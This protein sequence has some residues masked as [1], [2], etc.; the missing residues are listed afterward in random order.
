VSVRVNKE[1]TFRK[2]IN[3]LRAYAVLAVMFYHF[4]VP[5]FSGGFVGVDV[6]FVISGYLMTKIIIEKLDKPEGGPWQTLLDFYFARAYRIVPALVGLCAVL[7]ALG[8]FIFSS[9]DYKQLGIHALSALLFLSN[10]KFWREAGYFDVASHDKW[11]LHTWSLSVEWQFYLLFPLLVILAWRFFQKRSAIT[12][13]L[14]LGFVV[15]LAASLSL[16]KD[17][18]GAAFYLLP[19]RAWELFAGGL[20]YI[21]ATRV[22]LS[23]RAVRLMEFTGFSVIFFSVSIFSPETLWPGAYALFPVLG[24]VL[25]L[26]AA[27]QTSFITYTQP[28][29]ALGSWSYSVYLWHWPVVVALVWTEL[30][31]QW[32]AIGVGL[33]ISLVLGWLS[34]TY[35]ER[36][37]RRTL[38]KRRSLPAKLAVGSAIAIVAASAF[39][40][41]GTHGVEGRISLQIEQ[42]AQEANNRNPRDLECHS[43]GGNDFRQCRYGGPDIRAILVGDSHASA[44]ATALAAALP[45]SDNGLLSFTY[46]SCP[47]IFGIKKRDRSDLRCSEFNEWFLRKTSEIPANIPVVVV[48]RTSGYLL[49]SNRK[50]E[51]GYGKPTGYFTEPLDRPNSDFQSLFFEKINESACRLAAIRSTYLVRP[52]P[53]MDLDVPQ[54]AARRLLLGLPQEILIT[55]QDYHKRHQ[56]VWSAQDAAVKACGVR[57]LDPLPYLCDKNN[58]F[59]LFEGKP[60]YYDSH[61][62][63]EYGNKRLLP[64]FVEL[65]KTP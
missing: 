39:T 56:L 40:I 8:W 15:S 37:T 7:L 2:D 22:S 60:I 27:R 20:V 38:S 31:G 46:T 29:Q 33:T 61:H 16:T 10:F 52:I 41:W 53:E 50:V 6:F 45:N 13:A 9:I 57:V 42:V 28:I 24:T 51:L 65:F 58:C 54:T 32:H 21:Y 17:Y 47:T 35:V 44:V 1:I 25:I 3:A 63:S 4:G 36:P 48:N 30:A 11:L 43:Y 18:P 23:N 34:Y 55:R 14:I 62:L 5:G 59:G 64:M 12:V 49:G 26:L 19:T